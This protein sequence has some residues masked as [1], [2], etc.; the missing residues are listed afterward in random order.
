MHYKIM[1][2]GRDRQVHSNANLGVNTQTKDIKND[3]AFQSWNKPQE[4]IQSIPFP[5]TGFNESL[6]K[7]EKK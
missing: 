3:A 2:D 1:K 5:K 6:G 4:M 7:N